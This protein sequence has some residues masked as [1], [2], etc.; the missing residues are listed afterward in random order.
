MSQDA[1]FAMVVSTGECA[2]VLQRFDDGSLEAR[3]LL[4]D[5]PVV[6]AY[7]EWDSV[8][9][10]PSDTDGRDTASVL[11]SIENEARNASSAPQEVLREFVE[12]IE[13]V[14]IGEVLV[15]GWT[16]LLFTWVRARTALNALDDNG[17]EGPGV[18]GLVEKRDE[19]E[20]RL[21]RRL[22]PI[23]K[24]LRAADE[25][26]EEWE[27]ESVR[28]LPSPDGGPD[29]LRLQFRAPLDGLGGGV[30]RQ[31]VYLP[32][33]LITDGQDEAWRDFL[34]GDGLRRAQS[35]GRDI[36]DIGFK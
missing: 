9:R 24:R 29:L 23:I 26:E 1:E 3:P 32:V 2:R 16:D 35:R 10:L 22:A 11:S 30:A 36:E 28:A 25:L 4:E 13:R 12:D 6:L 19:L 18:R 14:G 31:G 20:E 34:A 27:F 21:E 33:D 15:D 5:E 17:E 8:P 7:G